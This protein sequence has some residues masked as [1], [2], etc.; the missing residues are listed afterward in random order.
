MSDTS[1]HITGLNDGIAPTPA[2][3]DAT[4]VGQAEA[5]QTGSLAD[6]AADWTD[7]EG[8]PLPT[9]DTTLPA[10]PVIAWSTIF[11]GGA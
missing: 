8:S 3:H 2:G 10:A 11:G 9:A 4:E 6:H 5:A 7:S 1:G